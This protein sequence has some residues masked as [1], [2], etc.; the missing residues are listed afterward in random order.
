MVMSI[1]LLY[2]LLISRYVNIIPYTN[3]KN[4]LNLLPI[5]YRDEQVPEIYNFQK[6]SKNVFIESGYF[7]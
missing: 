2:A 6:I 4:W 3:I 5:D 7:H 1:D